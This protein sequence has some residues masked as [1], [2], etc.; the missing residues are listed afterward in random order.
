VT[1]ARTQFILVRHGETDWNRLGRIQGHLDSPLNPQGVAQAESVAARL[2]HEPFDR[3]VCSDL[4][5]ARSTAEII[6]RRTGHTAEADARLRERHYGIFQGLTRAEARSTYSDAYAEYEAEDVDHAIPGGE[7][8]RACFRRN[9]ACLQELAARHAGSRIVVVAHGGVLDGLHRH[10]LGL[11]HVGARVFTIV[12]ASL[13]WFSYENGSWI[14]ERWGDV[15]HLGRDDA[16]DDLP[17]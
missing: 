12:N 13:N 8:V 15:A 6:A 17:R 3:L 5:R 11:P 16:L 2:S 9:L 1:T 10:A 7:S 4:G 14:L